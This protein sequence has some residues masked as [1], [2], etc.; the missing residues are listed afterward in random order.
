MVNRMNITAG[1]HKAEITI[2]TPYQKVVVPVYMVVTE[3]V[4]Y[5]RFG[6]ISFCDSRL[7]VTFNGCYKSGNDVTLMFFI[8]NDS[9][10]NISGLKLWQHPNYTYFIDDLGNRYTKDT[11]TYANIGSA[12]GTGDLTTRLDAR[13][14]IHCSV[15]I[16]NVNRNAK[17]LKSVVLRVYNYGTGDFECTDKEIIFTNVH[18]TN[19]DTLF[20]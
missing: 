2:T 9:G 4:P 10:K 15:T 7:P 13:T 12:S 17:Y 16:H 5:G 1:E 8:R 6:S 3:F 19:L 18:W 14:S 11:G 20:D